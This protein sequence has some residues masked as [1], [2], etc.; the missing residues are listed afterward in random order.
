MI[1]QKYG[2]SSVASSEKIKTIAEK[3]KERVKGGEKIVVVVSAMGKTTNSLIDLAN[4]ISTTPSPRELDMLLATG[5]QVTAALLAM[6]LVNTSVEAVSMNA[7]QLGLLTSDHYTNARIMDI[8]L[9]KLNS[10]L[11]KRKVVVV[12]GFQGITEGGD[13]TTL[14][15]GGSDTSAV[16]IAAKLG[17]PCEIYSDVAGIFT[18]DPKLHPGAKK[19]DYITY[20]EILEMAAL[21]AKVLH[22]RSVEIAKKHGVELYCGSTF[23]DERGTYVVNAFPE[24]LEQPV[25]TGAS[26]DSNQI[27]VTLNNIPSDVEVISGV[28]NSVAEKGL[29]VDMI[30]IVNVNGHGHVTFTVVGGNMQILKTA[31]EKALS[32]YS[33]WGFHEDADVTKVSV[34]GLGMS[35]RSGVAARFFNVMREAKVK[36]IA[37][38]TSEIK[39]SVLVNKS[40]SGKALKA[41]IDEFQL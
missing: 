37:T 2:G 6:A 33:G 4:E 41:L 14:G 34:V 20:D 28:F 22:S 10:E 38:T 16:A 39:I 8:N 36:I 21:G 32:N 40:D 19:L 24:W 13:L 5:E 23:S 27:K 1:V 31:I 29:N 17:T 35:A 26:V 30:S 18:C 25:V 11:E 9:T 15:R 3:I 12:T 7:F